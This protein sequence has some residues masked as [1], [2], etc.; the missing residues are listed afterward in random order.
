MTTVEARWVSSGRRIY[1]GAHCLC[2]GTNWG[3]LKG[4]PRACKVTT[5]MACETPQCMSN[6]L[7]RGQCG[8]CLIGLLRGWSGSNCTCDY[9]ACLQPAIVRVD[10]LNKNRCALHV[11]RG[12]WVGYIK[13]RLEER[14]KHFKLV[15][16]LEVP[17]L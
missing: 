4:E 16:P 14:D 6:G 3:I 17:F 2:C 11:E 1:E 13:K 8:I 7:A 10:G 5:C 12:K 15:G 9:K